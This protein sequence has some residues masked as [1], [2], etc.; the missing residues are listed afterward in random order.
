MEI[1]YEI[2]KIQFIILY[3]M[4]KARVNVIRQSI[5]HDTRK[6]EGML[7]FQINKETVNPTAVVS[8]YLIRKIYTYIHNNI[9]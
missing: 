1:W 7:G 4:D 3:T 5:Q 2:K 9:Y 6:R 8:K